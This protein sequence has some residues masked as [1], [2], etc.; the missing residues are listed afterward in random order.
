MNIV[1]SDTSSHV[2]SWLHQFIIFASCVNMFVCK[3]YLYEK[4]DESESR[5]ERATGSSLINFVNIF[6]RPI[7]TV[8]ATTN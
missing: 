7:L 4:R 3:I 6:S 1:K 8:K 5:R 2:A